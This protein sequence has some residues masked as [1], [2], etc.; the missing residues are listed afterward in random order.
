MTGQTFSGLPIF[1]AEFTNVNTRE[2]NEFLK[3]F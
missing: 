2:A 3:I 1:E